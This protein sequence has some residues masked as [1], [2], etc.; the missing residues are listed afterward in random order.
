MAETRK[1]TIEILGDG[2]TSS[3]GNKAKDPQQKLDAVLKKQALAEKKA[4]EENALLFKSYLLN[5]TWQQSKNLLT[6]AFSTNLDRMLNLKENYLAQ[7]EYNNFKVGISKATSFIGT[8]ASGAI[9]GA[10]IGGGYG[11]V[12]G[13]VIGTAGWVGNQII[14]NRANLSSYYQNLNTLNYNTGFSR[15][16]AGLVDGGRGTE[17]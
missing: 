1:I 2:L 7:N 13:A 3:S 4:L 8:V 17:N 15:T 6:N 5:S 14:D 9:T 10:Q 11:A 16:R 12:A